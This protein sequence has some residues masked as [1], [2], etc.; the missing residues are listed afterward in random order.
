MTPQTLAVTLALAGLEYTT[1]TL[2]PLTDL[3]TQILPQYIYYLLYYAFPSTY[4][5]YS[6][7]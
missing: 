4:H 5:L 2:T 1:P 6:C 7:I 3:F